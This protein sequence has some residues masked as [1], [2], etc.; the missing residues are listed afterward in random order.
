MVDGASNE[1]MITV[2]VVPQGSV[3]GPL[4]FILYTS[5]MFERGWWRTD[6]IMLMLMTSHYWQ[7]FTSQQTDLLLLPPLAGTWLGFRNG[8]I[9]SA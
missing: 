2:S 6:N 8:A 9:N 5:E 3:L 1:W 4:L 7:F